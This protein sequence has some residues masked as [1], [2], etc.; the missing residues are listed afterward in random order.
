MQY[1]RAIAGVFMGAG[2]LLLI[3]TGETPAGVG[4]LGMMG[5]FFIGEYNGKMKDP[6]L[7]EYNG[8]K[9]AET[10]SD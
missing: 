2:A 1:L 6:S 9:E 3:Y 5:G 8:K 7:G 10:E 4:L